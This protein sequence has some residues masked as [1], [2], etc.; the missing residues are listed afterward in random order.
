[1][2]VFAS[3]IGDEI[4]VTSPTPGQEA[5]WTKWI[6]WTLALIRQRYPDTS[7]LDQSVLDMVVTSVVADKAGNPQRVTQVDVAVDDGRVSK[8]YATSKGILSAILEDWWDTLAPAES[9]S[10]DSWST[11]PVYQPDPVPYLGDCHAW[12]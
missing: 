7:V 2:T 9:R 12:R 8:R 5:L 3:D 6:D 1:M 11:R 4:G 10:P